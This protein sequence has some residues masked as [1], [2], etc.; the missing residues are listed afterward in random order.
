[1]IYFITGVPGSGKSAFAVNLIYES[2]VNEKSKTYNT[3][4]Y[5]YT[6]I[7]GFKIDDERLKGRVH[8]LDFDIVVAFATLDYNLLQL[9]KHIQ[10]Y[11][12]EILSLFDYLERSEYPHATS[13][14]LPDDFSYY[15][16]KLKGH[17]FK[18]C[19]FVIDECHNFFDKKSSVLIRWLTYHRH[20]YQDICLITQDLALVD[21]SYKT[22]SIT[23]S[24]YKAFNPRFRLFSNHLRYEKNANPR[25]FAKTKLEI[26][27]VKAD[28]KIFELY[29]SGE[30]RKQLPF[31][32]KLIFIC[33]IC[34]FLFIFVIRNAFSTHEE[35]F[36]G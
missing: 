21:A 4:D 18:K 5:C 30:N 17:K 13:F 9:N 24:Y 22:S 28:P 29:T 2:F 34:L 3:F 36:T 15:F 27:T 7:N 19:L 11:D 33:V 26:L 35:G 20:F 8:W 25:F 16:E 1:M 32:Y 23:D 10:N 12:D 31:V 6:N 14:N